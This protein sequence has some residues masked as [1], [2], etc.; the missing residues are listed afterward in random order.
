MLQ[1]A[2]IADHHCVITISEQLGGQLLVLGDAVCSVDQT[3]VEQQ[4]R[5]TQGGCMT[6][7]GC[8]MAHS[9]CG[10]ASDSLEVWHASI[11]LGGAS[12]RVGVWLSEWVPHSRCVLTH[13]VVNDSLTMSTVITGVRAHLGTAH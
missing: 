2:G 9:G 1:G 10:L 4:H 12:F 7:S 6:L 11:R 8:G 3:D 5:L 13:S